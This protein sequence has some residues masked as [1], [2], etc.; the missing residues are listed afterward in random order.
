M[1]LRFPILIQPEPYNGYAS[2]IAECAQQFAHLHKMDAVSL[3][4]ATY[5]MTSIALSRIIEKKDAD[6][7]ERRSRLALLQQMHG[8]LTGLTNGLGE[9]LRSQAGS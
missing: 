8:V 6:S 3:V 5:N 2:R 1:N 9:Y 4:T 7:V